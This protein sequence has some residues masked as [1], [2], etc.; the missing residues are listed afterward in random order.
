[1]SEVELEL[2]RADIEA[3]PEALRHQLLAF[4]EERMGLTAAKAT[5]L[6]RDQVAT[7]LREISFH[8]WGRDLRL[9]L[10]ALAYTNE[11]ARQKLLDLLPKRD[12]TQLDRYIA[13]LNRLA[14]K[15][16]NAPTAQLCCLQP[17][18]NTYSA[19]PRTRHH[20]R[21]LL[22]GIERAGENEEPLWE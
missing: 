5:S 6:E 4:V 22:P 19:D 14:A 9:L 1:V 18:K 3:M 13:T 8:E 10:H 2:T 11:P 16:V 15:V 7:L 12:R 17:A 20:L 21:D